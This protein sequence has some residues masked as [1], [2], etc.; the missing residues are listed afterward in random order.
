VCISLSLFRDH[1]YTRKERKSLKKNTRMDIYIQTIES[2]K[3]DTCMDIYMQTIESTKQDICMDVYT[4]VH[5][6]TYMYRYKCTCVYT[7]IHMS[8]FRDMHMYI[9]RMTYV[10]RKTYVCTCTYAY[11][12]YPYTCMDISIRDMYICISHMSYTHIYIYM[13]MYICI[14][15][16][17]TCT[18]T[19]V[20]M[21]THMYRHTYGLS[22]ETL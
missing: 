18:C 15:H 10:I 2:L 9:C 20:W 8:F 5:V 4:Y 11:L 12:I 13:Y 22:L 19:Y 14:S 17:C 21:Y 1:I 7:S 16:I 6:Q 3:K